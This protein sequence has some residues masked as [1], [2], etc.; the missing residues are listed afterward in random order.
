MAIGD[1]LVIDW[2]GASVA[3]TVG[4]VTFYLSSIPD[5]GLFAS[6][7]ETEDAGELG[8][9]YIGVERPLPRQIA[10]TVDGV[11]ADSVTDPV[12]RY[13]RLMAGWAALRAD[14]TPARGVQE[15]GFTM[16]DINGVA[17]R[18]HA[19]ARASVEPSFRLVNEGGK[20]SYGGRLSGRLKW[21]A[22]FTANWP[23]LIGPEQ[24]T[25]INTAI[26]GTYEVHNH[27]ERNCGWQLEITT[28]VNPPPDWITVAFGNGSQVKIVPRPGLIAPAA[29][30]NVYTFD[31]FY[32]NPQDWTSVETLAGDVTSYGPYQ[33]GLGSNSGLMPPDSAFDPSPNNVV[34]QCNVGA[35]AGTL[36]FR[37]HFRDIT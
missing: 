15:L 23:Y 31:W 1:E 14:H 12:D 9:V 19:Q 13:R 36:R 17:Y 35:I 27:G 20:D 26:T 28:I 25:A 24:S 34:I 30:P 2:A 4:Q 33:A 37:E 29:P 21:L 10:F 8:Q 7:R 16:K 3:R 11:V 5:L 6:E 18:R 32:S 22:S